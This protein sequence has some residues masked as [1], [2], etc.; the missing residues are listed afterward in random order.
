MN[1]PQGLEQAQSF[2]SCH[3][4]PPT[5]PPAP[6]RLA[7]TFSRQAGSGA[8]LV[9]R[10]LAGLLDRQA[11][12]EEGVKWTVFD[13]ELVEK[14][15][16]DHN[17][18]KQLAEFMPEDRVSMLNDMI[19]ELLGLHPPSW[20]LARSTSDTILKLAELGNVILI[21]RGSVLITAKLPHVL[22]VRLVGSI[23]QRIRRIVEHLHLDRKAA[24][25]FIE[26]ADRGHARY[27][28]EHF[29]AEI[30]NPLLYD[31]ILNTDRVDIPLAAQLIAETLL[32]V[33]GKPRDPQAN[34]AT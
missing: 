34:K 17:L 16:A 26:K 27:V 7:V 10:E 29:R 8:W 24:A 20:T 22:H 30:E 6:R 14:V 28:R 4:R 11:P 1:L 31:L 13:K 25:E 18:A 2:I 19:T 3:V 21:G 12:G 5:R 23:E 15:L 9:A 32:R 33:A